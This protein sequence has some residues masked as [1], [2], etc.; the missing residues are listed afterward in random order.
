M[1]QLRKHL[2]W[3]GPVQA[4]SRS[5]I[6]PMGNGIQRP[7]G[8]AGQVGPLRQ[9]LTQQTVGVLVRAALP[10]AM[11]IR[12]EYSDRKPLGQALV[13]GHLFSPIIGQRG[14]QRGGYTREFSGESLSGTHRIRPVE[15]GQND[16]ARRS[17]DQAADG[18]SIACALDKVDFPVAGSTE[19][20]SR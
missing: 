2:Q 16:Q 18:R 15:S 11:R 12:K 13:F 20:R 14:P 4:F 17:F 7:L 3:R 8:I 9:I 1:T 10:W 5:G 19:R 6:Q